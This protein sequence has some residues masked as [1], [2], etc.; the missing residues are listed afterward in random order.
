MDMPDDLMRWVFES[1]LGWPERCTGK[2]ESMVQ[3]HGGLVGQ[4][5]GGEEGMMW[6]MA[7][8]EEGVP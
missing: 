7:L 3:T 8:A 2:A 6:G 1:C 5:K 4:E